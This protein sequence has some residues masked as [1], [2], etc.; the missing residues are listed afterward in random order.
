MSQENVILIRNEGGGVAWV[1]TGIEFHED[2]GTDPNP[3]TV[4][5]TPALITLNEQANKM[6]SWKYTLV[7]ESGGETY[8][9]DP[10]IVIK[11]M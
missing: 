4:N 9:D 1:F 2:S 5:L 7:I 8:R 6:E 11:A 3:F 10:R